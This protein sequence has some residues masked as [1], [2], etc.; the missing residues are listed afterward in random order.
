MMDIFYAVALI[1]GGFLLVNGRNI[2]YN[3]E[4]YRKVAFLKGRSFLCNI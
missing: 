2:C 4:N 1:D 3:T